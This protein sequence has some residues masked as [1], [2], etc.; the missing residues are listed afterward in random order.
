MVKFWHRH[1]YFHRR[2]LWPIL[3]DGVG[4]RGN[5]AMKN[6]TSYSEDHPSLHFQ[7]YIAL[8]MQCNI[9]PVSTPVYFPSTPSKSC[10]FRLYLLGPMLLRRVM[11]CRRLVDVWGRERAEWVRW[12]RVSHRSYTRPRLLY[13]NANRTRQIFVQFPPTIALPE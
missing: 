2:R 11:Q 3:R 4:L 5:H 12:H 10:I 1:F 8:L 9:I 7:T 6:N 13:K